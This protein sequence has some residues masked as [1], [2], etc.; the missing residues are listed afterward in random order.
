MPAPQGVAAPSH[1]PAPDGGS[2]RRRS[3]AALAQRPPFA[4]VRRPAICRLSCLP[5]PPAARTGLPDPVRPSPALSGGRGLAR[6]PA[7]RR[8]GWQPQL[9]VMAA[10]RAAMPPPPA[11]PLNLGQLRLCS[12]EPSSRCPPARTDPRRTPG[13]KFDTR[14]PAATGCTPFLAFSRNGTNYFLRRP[15]ALT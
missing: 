1:R 5:F 15:P 10:A 4:A 8:G 9:R 3:P 13:P 11:V 2:P 7:A 6:L 14:S 12:G